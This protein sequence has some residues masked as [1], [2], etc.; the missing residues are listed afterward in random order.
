MLKFKC[1]TCRKTGHLKNDYPKIGS[2]D[3]FVCESVNALVVTVLEIENTWLR[4]SGR[5][6]HMHMRK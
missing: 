4:D 2:K 5:S 3:D 6:Y 1:F